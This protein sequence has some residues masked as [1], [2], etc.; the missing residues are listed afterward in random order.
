MFFLL[1]KLRKYFKNFKI[2]SQSDSQ[3]IWKLS[4]KKNEK[5]EKPELSHNKSATSYTKSKQCNMDLG[6]MKLIFLVNFGFSDVESIINSP[7]IC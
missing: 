2:C 4:H 7:F 6:I 5:I 1:L 3:K